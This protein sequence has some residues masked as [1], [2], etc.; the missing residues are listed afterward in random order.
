[1]IWLLLFL[2]WVIVYSRNVDFGRPSSDL[3]GTKDANLAIVNSQNNILFVLINEHLSY[4][5]QLI[6]VYCMSDEQKTNPCNKLIS[7]NVK[8]SIFERPRLP[9]YHH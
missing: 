3:F 5:T 1:M 4:K 6:D 2:H 8:F 7:S 9:I